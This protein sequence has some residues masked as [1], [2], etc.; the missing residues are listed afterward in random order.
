MI[1][2]C[3]HSED[4]GPIPCPPQCPAQCWPRHMFRR[5]LFGRWRL[6]PAYRHLWAA[7]HLELTRPPVCDRDACYDYAHP[8]AMN[9]SRKAHGCVPDVDRA[10]A[11]AEVRRLGSMT[12]AERLQEG[13]FEL[14]HLYG[15]CYGDP[16]NCPQHHGWNRS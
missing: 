16:W 5:T 11:S 10:L 3:T 12:L 6:R 2:E 7:R 9:A 8:E 13:R 14:F 1:T 15:E 4:D